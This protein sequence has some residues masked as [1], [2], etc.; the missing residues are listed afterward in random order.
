MTAV[1]RFN[2][3]VQQYDVYDLRVP[4]AVRG[5]FTLGRFDVLIILA[6]APTT[7]PFGA[8]YAP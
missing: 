7:L 1:F 6:S 5:L 3:A 2:N 4:P 8:I